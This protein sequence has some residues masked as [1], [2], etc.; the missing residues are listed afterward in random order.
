MG[1][2]LFAEGE[3]LIMWRAQF[4][5]DIQARIVSFNN[6]ARDLTNSNL[7]QA[8]VLTQADMANTIYDLWDQTLATLN[9]N[10]AAVS[11]NRKGAMTSDQAGAYLCWMTSLHHCH[12]CYC[13]EVSHMSGD[14]QEMA[15][16]LSHHHDLTDQ[17]LLTL[18]NHHFPQDKP[19]RM[20]HLPNGM[21]WL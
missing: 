10:T 1:G 20:C 15:N 9:N 2:V 8:G 3:E 4:P 11:R 18:F 14:T 21:L 13:H 16:T 19:W 5:E 7:E 17:Q 6:P 12:H